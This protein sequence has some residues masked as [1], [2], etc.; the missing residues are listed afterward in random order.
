MT[1]LAFDDTETYREGYEVQIF[2][3]QQQIWSAGAH[4]FD[5]SP[6]LRAVRPI[7]IKSKFFAVAFYGDDDDIYTHD[8]SNEDLRPNV[9]KYTENSWDEIGQ[10]KTER[11]KFGQGELL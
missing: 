1:F 3:S 5:Y 8:Y 11:R 2:D 4:F 6:K 7:T 10:M 9:F